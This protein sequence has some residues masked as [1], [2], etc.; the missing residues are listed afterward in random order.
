MGQIKLAGTSNHNIYCVSL[1]GHACNTADSASLE[2]PE[3]LSNLLVRFATM[4][5]IRENV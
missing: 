5:N 2:F 4:Y 1:M 3:K